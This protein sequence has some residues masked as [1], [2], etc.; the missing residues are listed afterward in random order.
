[1]LIESATHL[2]L[3]RENNEDRFLV[4]RFENGSVLLAVADGMGGHAGGEVAAEL[5]IESL[6]S[7]DGNGADPV[8][9]ILHAVGQAQKFILEASRFDRSFK[10]MGTTLTAVLVRDGSAHWTQVG[11]SRLCLFRDG[12]LHRITDDHTI[13]GMLLKKGEITKEQARVHPYGNVL[14]RCIGCDRFEPDSGVFEV[15]SADILMLSSDGLHDLIPDDEIQ[16]VLGRDT[17]L[18]EK[19]DALVQKSLDAGGRD[20]ITAILGMI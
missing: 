20:N 7:L 8:D 11:D 1:M 13:P 18:R 16:A 10:G 9:G 15:R 12:I 5:A 14:L 3:I 19:L 17:G 2:G 6:T 4:K